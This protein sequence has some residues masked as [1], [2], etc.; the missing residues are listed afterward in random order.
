MKRIH[1]VVYPPD[2]KYDGTWRKCR[3]LF[4]ALYIARKFGDGATIY[5]LADSPTTVIN[6]VVWKDS[7][8][9]FIKTWKGKK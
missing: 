8:Y 6:K 1:Y 7:V 9:E 2:Y 3:T 4:I 5:R